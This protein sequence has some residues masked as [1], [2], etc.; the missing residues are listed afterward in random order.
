MCDEAE[1]F[2][3][4]TDSSSPFACPDDV[5][6]EIA[7]STQTGAM[8]TTGGGF[9]NRWPRPAYQD[10]QVSGYM[11]VVT[12]SL[13][14]SYAAMT[15]LSHGSYTATGRRSRGGYIVQVSDYIALA[16]RRAKLPNASNYNSSGRGYPDIAAIGQN[17]PTVFNG[18]LDMVRHF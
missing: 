14:G 1:L 18:S 4:G 6:G 8:I 17:V 11:G 2:A 5:I 7:C 15:R 10:A 13:R 12:R 3:F 16:A 9:S